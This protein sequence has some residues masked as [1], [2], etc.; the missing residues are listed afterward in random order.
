MPFYLRGSFGLIV[1]QFL[2]YLGHYSSQ[3]FFYIPARTSQLI[4]FNTKC[5][6]LSLVDCAYGQMSEEKAISQK[7]YVMDH[8]N[9]IMKN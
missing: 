9:P 7:V 1:I 5:V 6:L 2:D 8:L 4:R 3:V